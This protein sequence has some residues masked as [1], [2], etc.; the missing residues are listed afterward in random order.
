MCVH[1]CMH[2]CAYMM[3]L[4]CVSMYLCSY[5]VVCLNQGIVGVSETCRL[6]LKVYLFVFVSFMDKHV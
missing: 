2:L 3:C 4:L 6:L 5:F 1:E